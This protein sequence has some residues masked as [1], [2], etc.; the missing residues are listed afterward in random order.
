MRSLSETSGG[1]GGVIAGLEDDEFDMLP[2]RL[3]LVEEEEVVEDED[4]GVGREEF[5]DNEG[6]VNGVESTDTSEL[7][8]R[9]FLD[10]EDEEEE[11]DENEDEG[12]G[13]RFGV[14]WMI[15]RLR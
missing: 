5:G 4:F 6:E 13:S 15:V 8:R 3:D 7:F 14:T 11:E 9:R 12:V 1:V 10:C 2:L